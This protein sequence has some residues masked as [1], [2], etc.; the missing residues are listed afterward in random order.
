ME[1]SVD[2]WNIIANELKFDWDLYNHCSM[3]NKVLN[4]VVRKVYDQFP[5]VITIQTLFSSNNDV[6]PCDPSLLIQRKNIKYKMTLKNDILRSHDSHCKLFR[7]EKYL[8]YEEKKP[9]YKNKFFKGIQFTECYS[10]SWVNEM[11]SYKGIQFVEFHINWLLK[12]K[13]I[14]VSYCGSTLV[15]IDICD[16]F[17]DNLN[18]TCNLI[19]MCNGRDKNM[20]GV[21]LY[22]EH[23]IQ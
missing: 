17:D 18:Q 4:Y 12:Q 16:I 11:K 8:Y 7:T 23:Q 15:E 20:R 1:L 13:I 2:S 22:R 21:F 6:N 9:V 14:Y 19:Y 10:N 5:K 3:V